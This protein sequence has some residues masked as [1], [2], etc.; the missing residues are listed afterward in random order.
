MSAYVEVLKMEPHAQCGPSIAYQTLSAYI[1]AQK[2]GSAGVPPLE[3]GR[4]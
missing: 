1:G 2:L 3:T 4:P